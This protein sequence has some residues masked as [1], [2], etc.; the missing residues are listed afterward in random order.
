MSWQPPGWQPPEWQPPDW[1]PPEY[2]IVQPVLPIPKVSFRS[3]D[4]KSI[5]D[6]YNRGTPLIPDYEFY[7][8]R[9]F[10]Q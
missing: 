1:E 9:K 5:A 6:V 3:M 7:G 4:A 2:E 10:Y 8:R